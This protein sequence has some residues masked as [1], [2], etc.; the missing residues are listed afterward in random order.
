MSN[1]ASV[2]IPT[3]Y[4]NSDLLEAI[5]SVKSQT[6]TNV[7]II[8]VDDSGEG[9]AAPAV[10]E[11]NVMYIK[12]SKNEGPIGAWNTGVEASSGDF[13]QI[14]DDDDRLRPTKLEKQ[15]SLLKQNQNIGVAHCGFEWDFGIAE[16][17]N[18][19][20]QGD[21]LNEVLTL[22]SSP[23]ITSTILFRRKFVEEIF[24]LKQ[25]RGAADD[26]LKIELAQL[27]HFDYINEILIDRGVDNSNISDSNEAINACFQIIYDYE[28][29]YNNTNPDVKNKAYSK[30]YARKALTELDQN[31]W[32][33]NTI[34]YF[35]KANQYSPNINI[36]LIVS[37]ILA[38]G[39]RPTYAIADRAMNF[40]KRTLK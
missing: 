3:Y 11:L 36:K 1:L 10:E 9:H 4:R 40:I 2:I 35:I 7:E 26:V 30:T 18:P 15:I 22:N 23:C 25:Y 27:T 31:I 21:V 19:N 29:L 33:F 38:I 16:K 13:I 8:V 5:R 20:H 39:G 12:H 17:P 34:K 37:L 6:Y 14:L 28:G 32:S 24:P